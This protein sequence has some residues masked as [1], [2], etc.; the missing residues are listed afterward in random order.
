MSARSTRLEEAGA[1]VEEARKTEAISVASAEIG[2]VTKRLS[3][4]NPYRPSTSSPL[5]LLG[6][7]SNDTLD[8]RCS[9]P[10]DELRHVDQQPRSRLHP[11]YDHSPSAASSPRA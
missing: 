7:M 1:A 2:P 8:T 10:T 4:M 5:P 6:Q 9:R 3:R 11:C